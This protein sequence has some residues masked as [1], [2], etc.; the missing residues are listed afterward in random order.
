LDFLGVLEVPEVLEVM[1]VMEIMGVLGFLTVMGI[2]L[3]AVNLFVHL[4]KLFFNGDLRYQF[5][6]INKGS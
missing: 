2:L 1:E 6:Q 3:A 4:I 5:N